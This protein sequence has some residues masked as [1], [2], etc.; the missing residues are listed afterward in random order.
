VAQ[1]AYASND[2]EVTTD[3]GS[4]FTVVGINSAKTVAGTDGEYRKVG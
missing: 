3:K 2:D 1:R 4:K